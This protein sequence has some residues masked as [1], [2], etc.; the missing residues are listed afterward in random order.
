MDDIEAARDRVSDLGGKTV[1]EVME[2]PVGRFAVVCDPTGTVFA[3]FQGHTPGATDTDRLPPEH[4]FCWSQLMTHDLAATVP[5]YSALFGWTAAEVPGGMVIFH[6]GD[7]AVASAMRLPEDSPAPNHW[8]PYIAVTD[9][10]ASIRIAASAGATV[11]HPPT[12]MP[13]MGRFSILIDPTG[14]TVALWKNLAAES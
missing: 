1:T 10:D 4:T 13:G 12:T 6:H 8:L 2:I 14:A 5:F 11:V 7:K 9:T 3:L